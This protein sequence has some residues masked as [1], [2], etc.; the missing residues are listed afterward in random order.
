MRSL[1]HQVADDAADFLE[2]LPQRPVGVTASAQ[3]IFAALEKPLP[4]SPLSP[5]SVL[6]DMVRDIDPGLVASAGPRFFGFVIGGAT[7]ASIAADWLTSVW[8]QNAQVYATSPAAAVVEEIVG[9]WLLALLQLPSKSSV[10]FVS[11]GQMAN[12]TALSAARNT[13]LMRAGWNLEENGLFGA[14][15]IT[16]FASDQ[17][18]ATIKN[19]LR[20]I[21]IGAAQ[22]K[23]IPSDDQGRMSLDAFAEQLGD[24]HDQQ[25]VLVSLQAGN[26]N[27]GAFEPIA[28]IAKL[29][30]GRNAWIHVDGA[31]GL[32]A[33]V[34]P[35]LRFLLQGLDQA[36]SWATDAHKWLNVPH[37]SGI[38]FV[39]HA[40][41]HRSLKTTRCAYAGEELTDKRDGSVWTPE[42][43]RRAR[44]FVLYAAMQA[45][46]R[47]GIQEMI[48][49]CCDLSREFA[50]AASRLPHA[51]ILN[52]VVLNQ[53][54][55]RFEPSNCP[56]MDAFHEA[57]ASEIQASG[58][59]WMGTT[60]WKDKTV[61]R[62]SISN[63]ATDSQSISQAIHLL[64]E[65]VARM[66]RS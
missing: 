39:K 22:I 7:P 10:G 28:T 17:V 52:E 25:P 40:A 61:L 29:V 46:G 20:M 13:L 65:I 37:D 43:S 6:K 64:A 48:E 1:L 15:P 54:L 30:N 19:A 24:I 12:F 27:T 14:P 33:A 62:I 45:L 18:H 50:E 16:V 9:R 51:H 57:L 21:G 36:D 5:A 58:L 26:V 66:T 47:K 2:S 34:S 32:W 55:L 3:D 35:K 8:D 56:D 31:F 60:R 42:N 38:V 23:V 53:V 41:D 59:C 11:G 44:A 63:W 49:R 4:E